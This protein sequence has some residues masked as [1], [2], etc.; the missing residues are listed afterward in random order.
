MTYLDYAASA[1]PYPQ[2]AERQYRVMTDTF[3]NPGAIH[4]PGNQARRLLQESRRTIAK[5]L[6]VREQEVFFT[7]GGTEA[8]NWAVQLGTPGKKHIVAAAT[9]HKSVLEP[10]RQLEK[11]GYSVTYVAPDQTGRILADAVEKAITPDTG[12]LCVQAVNN[13]TGVI[14]D[15]DALAE[16]AKKRRIPYF[17][18]AVQSF[19]HVRQNLNKASILSLSAHKFGGPRGIGC[20]VVR[21]PIFPGPMIQG[22]GQE[23]GRRSGTENVPGAAGLAL[24]AELAMAELDAENARLRELT[25]ILEQKLKA[26]APGH[27]INGEGA[28]RHPG[29][30][31]CRFP[32]VSGEEMAARLDFKGICV[33][34]G[35]ACAAREGRPS[36]VLLAMGQTEQQAT[37]A[38]RF[39]IGRLT[40]VDEINATAQAVAEIL[41]Q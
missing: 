4:G 13:E 19:G 33:S 28:P 27:V 31:N 11:E 12:L 8:N 29:I 7:S 35:A 23:Q 5:L 24:A 10:L 39:S 21:Y 15:V 17:C 40:T 26:V 20:L 2:A 38:V 16:L 32:G 18:D 41:N 37:E 3:G 9:E 22:G 34:P 30:L 1:L 14:Q 25:E 36:H 6:N